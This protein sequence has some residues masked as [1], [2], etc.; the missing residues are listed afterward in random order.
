LLLSCLAL[1]AAD[2]P[3]DGN[4][5]IR[6]KV[7]DDEIVLTT[8]ARV[9]GAIGSLKFNGK[10]FLDSF[11]HGRQMQSAI[12]LDCGKEL[13]D[14]TYNPTEAGCRADGAGPNSSSKLLS[15]EAK[16][17]ELST[18]TR[19]AFWLRPGE[20]SGKHMAY[21]QE[22]LSKH[23]VAKRVHIGYKDLPNV[24]DY[25]VTFTIPRGEK[26]TNAVFE[27]LTAYLPGEFEK[28]NKYDP[29]RGRLDPLNDGPGEQQLPPLFSTKNGSHALG[30]FSP[31]H[32]S[33]QYKKSGY[34]R[35]RFKDEK[36]VKWNCVFRHEDRTGIK[37][38]DYT[39][40]MFVVVGSRDECAKTMKKLHVMFKHEK[41]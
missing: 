8:T 31:D 34:G 26:H 41:P 30:V 40:Q 10:E 33:R 39:F 38:G 4:S 1:T 2:K 27:A 16:G 32:P 13:H 29:V 24:I 11:D 19:M 17:N 6:G 5:A 18:R 21:N 36:V 20:K 35:W 3:P 15:L 22:A 23:I 12:N 14:E 37:A 28:F 9:A 7:G 25:R